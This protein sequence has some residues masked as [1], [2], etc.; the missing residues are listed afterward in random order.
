MKR[1]ALVLVLVVVSGGGAGWW[2]F[3]RDPGGAEA[4]V[5]AG[6]PAED[7][8]G[9]SERVIDLAPIN[10]PIIRQ[11]QVILH[12]SLVVAIELTQPMHFKEIERVLPPL[13]DAIFSELHA[14]FALRTIQGRGYDPPFV[15]DRLAQAGARVLGAGQVRSVLIKALGKRTPKRR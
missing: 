3:L 1:L 13:R 6:A 7:P 9:L 10:L 2:F 8:G 4:E 5:A 14:V 15:R 12:L 11:G